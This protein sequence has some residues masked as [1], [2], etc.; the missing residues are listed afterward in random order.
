M[1][2]TFEKEINTAPFVVA[3]NNP[4]YFLAFQSIYLFLAFNLFRLFPT[5]KKEGFVCNS[6]LFSLPIIP[7]SIP[8]PRNFF[9]GCS[10]LVLLARNKLRSTLVRKQNDRSSSWFALEG[11]CVPPIQ[12]RRLDYSRPPPHC[13]SSSASSSSSHRHRRSYAKKQSQN[14]IPQ[15][16]IF[17]SMILLAIHLPEPMV[18]PSAAVEASL[19]CR[20]RCACWVKIQVRGLLPEL[21]Q[22]IA[23]AVRTN[24]GTRQSVLR[25]ALVRNKKTFWEMRF[26]FSHISALFSFFSFFSFFFHHV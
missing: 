22:L 25:F 20:T 24:L 9:Y 26:S 1:Y 21:A 7:P 23:R 5:K 12:N 17:R 6:G 13:V 19:V 8:S 10:S 15:M 4:F 11:E 2:S 16:E 18:S 3:F 14:A